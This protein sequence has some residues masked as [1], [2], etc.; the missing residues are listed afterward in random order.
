MKFIWSLILLIASTHIFAVDVNRGQAVSFS[1]TSIITLFAFAFLAFKAITFG[2]DKSQPSSP[3]KKGRNFSAWVVGFV[4][5]SSSNFYVEPN[6][7]YF[8]RLS[9][10]TIPLG[11]VAFLVGVVWF[12]VK[13]LSAKE[14]NSQAISGL[15]IS[16]K[17]PIKGE[18]FFIG[19]VVVGLIGFLYVKVDL[20]SFIANQTSSISKDLIYKYYNCSGTN[21]DKDCQKELKGTATF[22]VDKDKSQVVVI[23][24]KIKDGQKTMIKL[25]NCT[26]LD[27]KNWKCGGHAESNAYIS[28]VNVGWTSVDGEIY[29]TNMI[30]TKIVGGQPQS[31]IVPSP[32]FK[33]E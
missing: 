4:I 21:Y 31:T 12:N 32:I 23:Y 10:I 17:S 6:A 9:L 26:V 28:T 7:E 5:L 24:D 18:T 14:A 29:T 2:I 27:D 30:M 16:L 25:E 15:K 33:R 22:K 19:L 3:S 11:L 20:A 1:I 8:Y 13:N